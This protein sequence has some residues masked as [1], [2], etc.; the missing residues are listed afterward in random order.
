V[1]GIPITTES[2][3]ETASERDG[4]VRLRLPQGDREVDHVLLATG[5]E[6]DVT[7]YEFLPD[8]LLRHVRRRGGYP[9]L[10]LGFESSLPGLHFVGAPAAVSL[11]PV[12]RF[13]CGTWAAARGVTRAI[14][15]RGVPRAGFSW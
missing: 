1:H 4:L 3:I 14:V 5:Y 2:P 10:D 12:F 15:G 8:S 9:L 6:V 13:V 7:R 11:G